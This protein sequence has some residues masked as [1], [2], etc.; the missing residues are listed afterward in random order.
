[1]SPSRLIVMLLVAGLLLAGCGE[2]DHDTLILTGSSTVAPPL[3]D[4]AAD[5]EAANPGVRV[6][7]Q[8]GGSSRGI[9]DVRRGTADLGMSSRD[10]RADEDDLLSHLVARDG[11]SLLVHRANPVTNLSD[12][13]VRKLFRGEIPNWS[14]LGDFDAPVTIVH[15]GEGRATLEV[16]LEHFQLNN[17]EVKPDLIVGENQQGIRSV[18]GNRGAI[19]YVSIGAATHEAE[20]GT[21]IRSLAIDG[22]T[23]D[24]DTVARG[25]YPLTR[26]LILVSNGPPEGLLADF[27]TFVH[28]DTG[29]Q[30][31]QKHFFTPAG[32][33]D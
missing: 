16:F 31:F 14:E 7:I 9:V 21:P 32:K 18:A 28:S 15:K 8:S 2:R 27:L 26:N 29:G 17:G 11:I 25:D 20:S 5:F 4:I 1:M 33:G 22:V 23:P 6:D 12:E 10:L 30:R 24:A 13:Q 19:G 3:S